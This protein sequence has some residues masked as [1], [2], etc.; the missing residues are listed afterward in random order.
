MG[1][2][3]SLVVQ[4]EGGS[5]E[6]LWLG[7]GGPPAFISCPVR[8]W[9]YVGELGLREGRPPTVISCLVRGWSRWGS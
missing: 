3:P 9:E 6:E 4:L 2:L 5:R 8:G 1:H 7:G